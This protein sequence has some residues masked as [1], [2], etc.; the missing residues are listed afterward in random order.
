MV[1]TIHDDPQGR[2]A[3]GVYA[4]GTIPPG[5]APESM[6]LRTQR[7]EPANHPIS[8]NGKRSG[9]SR[10]RR[11]PAVCIASGMRDV[12]HENTSATL[13]A[14]C[15]APF[16]AP[17]A[18]IRVRPPPT[19]SR[20]RFRIG[21]RPSRTRHGPAAAVAGPRPRDPLRDDRCRTRRGTRTAA[22]R[23][24]PAAAA[25]RPVP[26]TARRRTAAPVPTPSQVSAGVP[27][28]RGTGPAEGPRG[29]TYDPDRGGGALARREPA[30]DILISSNVGD[31]ERSDR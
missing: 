19:L 10:M 31:A 23:P 5:R 1:V 27:E 16:P 21:M 14:G 6:A 13:A 15:G 12:I 2:P 9:E 4:A 18:R 24:L 8:R 7:K 17:A 22:E 28:R 20:T 11:L 25:A 29:V 26:S 3:Q 30:R